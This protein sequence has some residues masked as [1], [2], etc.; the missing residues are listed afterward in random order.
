MNLTDEQTQALLELLY[1]L[2]KEHPEG[3]NEWAVVTELKRRR[4]APF[5]EADLG[6]SL[7]LF[8]VHFLLF[9][10]LYLLK[11]QVCQ[12]QETLEIHCL[13]IQLQ[14]QAVGGVPLTQHD[15]LRNY[16]LDWQTFEQTNQAEVSQM[17]DQ[18][19]GDYEKHTSAAE[20]FQALGLSADASTE[21]IKSKYR[22]LAQKL[23]PDTGGSGLGFEKITWAKKILVG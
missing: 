11:D 12:R 16:Y 20:A 6:D 18:F 14:P 10:L 1:D 17:L 23:H 8:Q 4:L 3:M 15:P 7:L 21:E 22:Q 9:H 13:K 5:A 2:L 19:W